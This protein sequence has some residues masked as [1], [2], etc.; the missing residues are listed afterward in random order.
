[1][2]AN[3]PDLC[4]ID[5]A[6]VD[7][8][9][10]RI[11]ILD[12]GLLYGDGVFEGIRVRHGRV[13][14]LG[15]HLARLAT[16]AR[17]IGLELPCPLG[18]IREIVLATVRARGTPEAYVRLLVTRGEGPLGVDPTPCGPARLAGGSA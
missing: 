1:M 14:R 16:G 4:W 18:A 15:D 10:A 9:E 17:A 11:S 8:H 12:H 13:F 7:A 2:S 6:I 3:P 5:G